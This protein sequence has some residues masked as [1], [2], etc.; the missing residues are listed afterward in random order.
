LDDTIEA[1]A[2]ATMTAISAVTTKASVIFKRRTICNLSRIWI[3]AD[4]LP[5]AADAAPADEE[6]IP[7]ANH[8]A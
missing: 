5:P 2:K 3:D 6:R 7:H 1:R 8:A 4:A